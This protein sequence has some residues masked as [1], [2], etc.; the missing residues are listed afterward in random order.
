MPPADQPLDAP[1]DRRAPDDERR[2]DAVVAAALTV[3]RRAFVEGRHVTRS[4]LAQEASVT[5][6]AAPEEALRLVDAEAARLGVSS[7]L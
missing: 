1:V 3:I 5:L 6:G 2:R 7:L 4:G